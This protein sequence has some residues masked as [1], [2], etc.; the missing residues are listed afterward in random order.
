M[1][2]VSVETYTGS[3][4]KFA[5]HEA[6]SAT[7]VFKTGH[8]YTGSWKEGK[9]HGRGVYK[10]VDGIVFE[11]YFANNVAN[12]FGKYAWPDG[13]RY[14]G[15]V[16]VG[17]RHGPGT[18][19]FADGDTSYSGDWVDGK[20]HGKG[21]IVFSEKS[22][23]HFYD[24]DWR[25]DRK[26][27][28]GFFQYPNLDWY[29]GEWADDK[30]HGKGQYRW[31]G[32][33]RNETYT[34]G[35][36]NGYAC[37]VGTHVWFLENIEDDSRNNS[38]SVRFS[39]NTNT[40]VGTFLDGKRSGHGTF[41]YAD[42]SRYV[43][44]FSND[45]KHGVGKYT[46][47]DGSVFCGNFKN[48]KPVINP[49]DPPFAP[50]THINLNVHELLDDCVTGDEKVFANKELDKSLLRLM[51]ELRGAYKVAAESLNSNTST[52]TVGAFVQF[53]RS[54]GITGCD[55][56]VAQLV[57]CIE[58]AWRDDGTAGGYIND[59]EIPLPTIEASDATE[60]HANVRDGVHL[61]PRAA[62]KK[63]APD[64]S[65]P[66]VL[67]DVLF[68]NTVLV[69]REFVEALVRCAHH[70]FNSTQYL[71]K[72]VEL[73]LKRYAFAE[74]RDLSWDVKLRESID[75]EQ[76][77]KVTQDGRVHSAF[78]EASR[79][80]PRDVTKRRD[81]VTVDG[82]SFLSFL[83]SKKVLVDAEDEG[84]EFVYPEPVQDEEGGEEG[85]ETAEET[86]EETPPEPPAEVEPPTEEPEQSE[87]VEPL[88]SALTSTNALAAFAAALAPVD[89]VEE[90]LLKQQEEEAE[91]EASEEA[92][93]NAEEER[94]ARR[95][96][97]EQEKEKK[98]EEFEARKAQAEE[99]GEEFTE[100]PEPESTDEEEAAE[101]EAAEAARAAEATALA[102]ALKSDRE[103]VRLSL[104]L[105]C[106]VT[107]SVFAEALSR[108]AELAVPD[109][110]TLVEQLDSFLGERF[111]DV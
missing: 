91:A 31:V 66:V 10:W 55:F 52:L 101:L 27:G 36:E 6:A 67:P 106:E 30:K 70:K 93:A 102:A 15:Q 76:L 21:K 73:L 75:M 104:V 16:R 38:S 62:V 71:H 41:Y 46:F 68:P 22:Q 23:E 108:C 65:D 61:D 60:L 69:F 12:G 83:T 87:V 90:A 85:A 54:R 100:E 81:P 86:K 11:G 80:R 29:K 107:Y 74:A 56:T 110:E 57:R 40:Y 13:G 25:D 59:E 50:T 89:S 95:Y 111:L 43:G 4:S 78:L 19:T 24:G 7:A 96:A 42:G 17:K 26:H 18:M 103:A 20:R 77:Q 32:D 49:G 72:R 88:V 9:M 47:H 5:W 48:D 84:E 79:T 63:Q 105:D 14:E 8:T 28:S 44:Q 109:A 45:E 94:S 97:A 37:G 34:G 64:A 1:A 51:S 33:G 39:T 3:V 35:F 92:A 58:P 2:S 53:A 98:K 99:K 82:R